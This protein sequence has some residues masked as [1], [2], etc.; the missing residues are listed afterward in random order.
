M[1]SSN[2]QPLPTPPT[3]EDLAAAAAAK[4]RERGNEAGAKKIENDAATNSAMNNAIQAPLRDANKSDTNDDDKYVI[5]PI[6][7]DVDNVDHGN[8]NTVGAPMVALAP[9]RQPMTTAEIPDTPQQNKSATTQEAQFEAGQS[10]QQATAAGKTAAQAD[11]DSLRSDLDYVKS[12]GDEA[13]QL[14]EKHQSRLAKGDAMLQQFDAERKDRESSSRDAALMSNIGGVFA[15]LA[16]GIMMKGGIKPEVAMKMVENH[17]AQEYQRQVNQIETAKQKGQEANNSLEWFRKNTM[18]QRQADLEWEQASDQMVL[19]K[20]GDLRKLGLNEAQGK[21]LDAQESAA[22]ARLLN[23]TNAQEKADAVR[24][25]VSQANVANKANQAGGA[26]VLGANQGTIPGIGVVQLSPKAQQAVAGSAQGVAQAP[27]SLAPPVPG[28]GSPGAPGVPSVTGQPGVTSSAIPATSRNVNNPNTNVMPNSTTS[29]G[30]SFAKVPVQSLHGDEQH[31]SGWNGQVLDPSKTVSI[32]P[33]KE[34]VGEDMMIDKG[35][36]PEYRKIVNAAVVL[37]QA[38][39]ELRKDVKRLKELRDKNGILSLN[40]G[41][42]GMGAAT[43]KERE[44]YAEAMSAYEVH[45]NAF[46]AALATHLSGTGQ[47]KSFSVEQAEEALGLGKLSGAMGAASRFRNP[48]VA[49]SG[50]TSA[51]NAAMTHA[52]KTVEEARGTYH[53]TPAKPLTVYGPDKNGNIVDTTIYVPVQA[54]GRY[55]NASIAPTFQA[56]GSLKK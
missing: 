29:A 46:T 2:G 39:L 53:V 54:P 17:Q 37:N 13:A 36:L 3:V 43:D 31:R 14:N 30:Q 35:Q 20:I 9:A 24:M 49:Y 4:E 23:T 5:K 45:S 1:T 28:Q 6:G 15:T 22:K 18:D 40:N 27:G 42:L 44:E 21:M 7:G 26:A 33:D 16:Q 50:V 8:I 38:G 52:V 55:G 51:I 47:G 11:A 12:A 25:T 32:P 10:I 56:P 48:D 34:M 19:R 41:V